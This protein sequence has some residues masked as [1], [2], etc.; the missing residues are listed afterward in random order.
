VYERGADRQ[1]WDDRKR[2]RSTRLKD[3]DYASPGAY[4]VTICAQHRRRIF[5]TIE[6]EQIRLSEIG[7]I[8]EQK[9]VWLERQYPHVILDEFIIMP[10]HLHG[11][12]FLQSVRRGGSRTAPTSKSKTLGRLIGAFKTTSTKQ[13]NNLLGTPGKPVWQRGFYDHIILDEEDLRRAR[14]YIRHNPGNWV[15]DPYHSRN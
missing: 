7:S 14:E 12:I 10:N 5:G 6:S 1:D 4:F 8:V 2:R 13:I 11:I 15:L 9:W 3:W